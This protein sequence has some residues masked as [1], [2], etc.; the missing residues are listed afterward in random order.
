MRVFDVGY[1]AVPWKYAEG[2]HPWASIWNMEVQRAKYEEEKGYE[3]KRMDEKTILEHYF[4]DMA[5]HDLLTSDEINK[6]ARTMT[7]SFE[8][9]VRILVL[10]RPVWAFI[11]E[12]WSTIRIEGRS[13][14]K[15]S[16]SYGSAS[17]DSKDL[18]DTIDTHIAIVSALIT[19]LQGEYNMGKVALIAKHLTDA[20]LSRRLW[21]QAAA[22]LLDNTAD[23]AL[24]DIVS[25]LLSTIQDSKDKMITANLRLVVNFAK[26]FPTASI[27]LSDLIQEGNLGL[28][29]AVEKYDP[30]RNIKF[31]TYAAWWIR[32]AFLR[33]IK[34]QGKTIRLPTHVYDTMTRFRRLQEEIRMNEHREPSVEE[35]AVLIDVKPQTIHRLLALQN[36]PISLT[37][38]IHKGEGAA[39]KT[40]S[41]FV[42]TEVANDE[43]ASAFVTSYSPDIEKE[44]DNKRRTA[45]INQQMKKLLT[46]ME[47][48]I[49][50]WR[51]GLNGH[52]VH[53]LEQIAE[54][55][56]RSRERVRQ[57][58]AGA[59]AKMREH[60]GFLEELQNGE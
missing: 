36:E 56:G 49:L 27:G 15:L 51:Y 52:E 54:K 39:P 23:K 24:S 19:E 21:I 55:L 12:E 2:K 53:T 57:I 5:G 10:Q 25:K 29:R 9:L 32:Q 34:S 18:T 22:H 43:D 46:V 31:S 13:S 44:M 33:C 45:S 59:N 20:G 8:G 47:R 1:H 40:I 38:E 6:Y 28:I 4:G 35:L 17:V 41:D 11:L 37:A 48:K 14:N 7:T 26:K 3:R 50:R 42:S 58:E 60:A 30:N 16:E